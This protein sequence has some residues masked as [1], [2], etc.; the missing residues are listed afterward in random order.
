MGSCYIF[1]K[2]EDEGIGPRLAGEFLE[3]AGSE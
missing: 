2:H 1:F 3:L